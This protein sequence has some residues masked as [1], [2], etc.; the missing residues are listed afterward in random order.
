[1]PNNP[2][3]NS[4]YILDNLGITTECRKN[5]NVFPCDNV[6]YGKKPVY[7]NKTGTVKLCDI[8]ITTGDYTF[9]EKCIDSNDTYYTERV[10][11]N[12]YL[13]DSRKDTYIDNDI[14]TCCGSN[15]LCKEGENP[16][17]NE[18]DNR[19]L[20]NAAY[21][22]SRE[23]QASNL[24]TCLKG[25]CVSVPS[26]YQSNPGRYPEIK[27]AVDKNGLFYSNQCNCVMDQSKC[28]NGNCEPKPNC[29]VCYTNPDISPVTPIG[30][31]TCNKG[32]CVSSPSGPYLNIDT[33][34][35]ACGTLDY[36]EYIPENIPKIITIYSLYFIVGVLLI[37]F[38]LLFLQAKKR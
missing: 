23:N 35:N 29:S 5:G 15:V 28:K 12:C 25:N 20:L 24:F 2:E 21:R 33:C 3:G 1:M 6:I 30:R 26:D 19:P 7:D 32:Q 13:A 34:Q 38:F 31:Y 9:N 4:I 8:D 27:A 14:P 36:S 37:Y 10:N 16:P 17:Q 18:T 22:I 11:G